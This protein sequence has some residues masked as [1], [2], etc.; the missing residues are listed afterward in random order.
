MVPRVTA[1][2]LSA[3]SSKLLMARFLGPN[4]AWKKGAYEVVK[5]MTFSRS[6]FLPSEDTIRST[7]LDCK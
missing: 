5:S 3:R 1:R 4:T 6:A 2:V 7:F